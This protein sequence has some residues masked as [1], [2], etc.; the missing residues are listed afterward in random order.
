MD[1][2]NARLPLILNEFDSEPGVGPFEQAVGAMSRFLHVSS[3]AF[4]VFFYNN[5]AVPVLSI[6]RAARSFAATVVPPGVR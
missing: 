2:L 6:W 4:L 1:N 5:L 3:I